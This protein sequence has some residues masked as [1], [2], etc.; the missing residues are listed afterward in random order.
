MQSI[1]QKVLIVSFFYCKTTL[2]YW[3]KMPSTILSPARTLAM[4][5]AMLNTF[6]ISFKVDLLQGSTA[7]FHLVFDA[8]FM[9]SPVTTF[10]CKRYS[11]GRVLLNCEDDLVL[12]RIFVWFR[13]VTL[14]AFVCVRVSQIILFF[15]EWI[16][17]IPYAHIGR[18]SGVSVVFFKAHV[19]RFG[20]VLFVYQF[21]HLH[22][23]VKYSKIRNIGKV[24]PCRKSNELSNLRKES[25][26]P[27][28]N[29]VPISVIFIVDNKE[30]STAVLLK[31][32]APGSI[33][34]RRV[35][36]AT[37]EYCRL[38]RCGRRNHFGVEIFWTNQI[39]GCP[40]WGG[41]DWHE[42]EGE[43]K[44]EKEKRWCRHALSSFQNFRHALLSFQKCR[45]ARL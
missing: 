18:V 21:F 11:V 2:F 36:G 3:S 33:C 16:S 25:A 45:D 19:G 4:F 39:L 43:E 1:S 10:R 40:I 32:P 6:D 28:S 9:A 41:C 22:Q 42:G 13:R 38:T 31:A 24:C 34:G 20:V 14:W 17:F 44:G 5:Y 15:C 26:S 37:P 29:V 27:K 7:S 23:S 35:R 8:L 30:S 12:A